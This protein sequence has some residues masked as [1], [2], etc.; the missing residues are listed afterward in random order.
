MLH[1]ERPLE[2][3]PD[4][5][6]L[7]HWDKVNKITDGVVGGGIDPRNGGRMYRLLP[8]EKGV[9]PAFIHLREAARCLTATIQN[10]NTC[11]T[12]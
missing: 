2:Y 6:H 4:W 3:A 5:D 12:W 9:A 8:E 7:D 1:M 10:I 11:F